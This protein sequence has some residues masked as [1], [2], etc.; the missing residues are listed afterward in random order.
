MILG[1]TLFFSETSLLLLFYGI[2]SPNRLF[3]YKLYGAFGF[4]ALTTLTSIPM[5]L[6]ICLPGSDGSWAEAQTRCKKTSV[7]S[8][9]QGPAAVAFDLFLLYLP[10][11]VVVQLHLPLRRKIGV[12]AIFMT[13]ML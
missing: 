11:S 4:I 5:Y 10:A 6:A 8:Y 9:V 13:G 7:Y 1:S 2:F 3:R 12:L